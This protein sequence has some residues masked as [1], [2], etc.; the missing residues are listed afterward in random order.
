M[1]VTILDPR[2]VPSTIFEAYS[3]PSGTPKAYTDSPNLAT[4]P[5]V[6]GQNDVV[7]GVLLF[8]ANSV[9]SVVSLVRDKHEKRCRLCYHPAR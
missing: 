9:A 8:S 4:I 1:C 2:E 6:Q 5:I 3:A 7:A